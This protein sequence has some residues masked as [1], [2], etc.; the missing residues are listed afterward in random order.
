MIKKL[1][2]KLLTKKMSC[3]AKHPLHLIS[4]SNSVTLWPGRGPARQGSILPGLCHGSSLALP[5]YPLSILKSRD[6]TLPT[7]VCIVKVMVF[8]VGMY[9]CESWTIKQAEGQRIDAFELWCWTG[10]LRFPWTARRSNQ[11][12]NFEKLN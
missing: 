8:P 7:N 2:K 12:K 9:G 6:M 3:V 1:K 4:C 11:N 5:L 10:L